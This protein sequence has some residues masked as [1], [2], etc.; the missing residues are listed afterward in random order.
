MP[1]WVTN[2]VSIEASPDV[3][4][5]IAGQLSAP[6]DRPRE[7]W[8]TKEVTVETVSEVIQFFNILR[9]TNLEE[10]Y[11]TAN[12]SQFENQLNW[13]NWNTSHWG[14]K[15]D[16]CDIQD[17]DTSDDGTVITYSFDTAWSP[18]VPVFLELS[19]QY[20]TAKISLSYREE[21]MW[22]G[23]VRYLNGEI[24][25]DNYYEWSCSYCTY[26]AGIDDQQGEWCDDCDN[27]V[28]PKCHLNYDEQ[29]CPHI[30]ELFKKEEVNA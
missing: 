30:E 8:M 11:K 1:N 22:G 3:I 16:A 2:S 18:P 25:E 28:C 23:H 26:E 9:P 24:T 19:R 27:T 6:Y 17:A 10:Y 21:Q 12:G 5:Q 7:D 29:E 15:W 14:T 4:K 13:Y 20:P